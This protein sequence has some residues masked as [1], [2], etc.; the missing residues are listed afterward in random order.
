ML[1]FPELWNE[2]AGE[3]V[4]IA[5]LDSGVAPRNT[6]LQEVVVSTHTVFGED[7]GGDGAGHGT[8][9]AGLLAGRSGSMCL[10]IAPRAE[11]VS[12]RTVDDFGFL[13]H[14]G[15]ERA[16]DLALAAGAHV[17]SVSLAVPELSLG[18]RA[19]FESII[20]DGAAIIIAA[21]E[22]RAG[23]PILFPAALNG[24][25]GVGAVT[26]ALRPL[27]SWPEER[28][29]M[30]LAAYGER[31]LT[32]T[33][34]GGLDLFSGTSAAVPLASGA[35]ALLLSLASSEAARRKAIPI[36]AQLLGESPTESVPWTIPPVLLNPK[37]AARAMATWLSTG[38]E[39]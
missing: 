8:R 21:T 12:I 33:Y 4:I 28:L 7:G 3:G 9:C 34:H 19:A 10:G 1:G 29:C 15:F 16:L 25:I 31:L 38:N 36:L 2:C 39:S 32:T 22:N 24:V 30:P 6:W 17:I 5:L 27:P 18:E 35:A 37:N 13:S 11:I 26:R 20:K 14:D 23:A